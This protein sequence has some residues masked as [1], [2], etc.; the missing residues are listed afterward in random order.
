[1]Q[2]KNLQA[3]ANQLGENFGRW[4]EAGEA[5]YSIRSGV[6]YLAHW[7]VSEPLFKQLDQL[8]E[9]YYGLQVVKRLIILYRCLGV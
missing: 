6:D 3:A 8:R 2:S 1:M 9:V 7:S 5:L 4:Q